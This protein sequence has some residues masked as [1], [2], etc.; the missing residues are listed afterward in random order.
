MPLFFIDIYVPKSNKNNIYSKYIMKFFVFIMNNNKN[1][2]H[3][4]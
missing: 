3:C 1:N 4:F 2:N